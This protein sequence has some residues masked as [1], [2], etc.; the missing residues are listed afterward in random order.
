MTSPRRELISLLR[1]YFACPMLAALDQMGLVERMRT[2]PFTLDDL[3]SENRSALS[4]TLAYLEALGLL[5]CNSQSWQCTEAGSYV[6][7]RVGIFHML[8]SYRVY[9]EDYSQSL[10]MSSDETLVHRLA[11]VADSG[12]L[13][14]RKYFPTVENWFADKHLQCIADV[15]CGNGEFL[16]VLLRA[17]ENASLIGIDLS[18]EAVNASQARFSAHRLALKF[19]PR[20]KNLWVN[21]GSGSAPKL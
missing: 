15:G 18:A 7:D 6:F 1:G 13:H 11:N 5:Q 17:H 12:Q 16:D 10:T 8:R 9:F 19:K 3:P 20:Q 21:S 4:A 14:A 2:G